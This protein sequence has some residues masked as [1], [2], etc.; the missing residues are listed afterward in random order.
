MDIGTQ[1]NQYRIVEH[2][3]RGGMADVWS[4]RDTRLNRMVAIKT[5]A[6]G[7][8]PEVDPISLFKQ[9]AQTIAQMEH[10]HILPIHDFGE[11]EGQLYIVMRY[12]AGGS[13]EDLLERGSM[14]IPEVIR[15]GTA[16]AQALDHAHS[17]DVVHLDLKPPNI[18]LDSND[19]PY[20]ADFGL[21]AVM[22]PEG[23]AQNPGS[24]TLLYMAPEQLMADELDHRADIYSFC[25]MLFHLLTG[26]LPFDSLVPLSLKQIQENQDIPPLASA[27]GE[28]PAELRLHPQAGHRPRPGRPPRQHPRPHARSRGCAQTGWGGDTARPVC[29]S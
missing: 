25:V 26:Q 22:N 9:E 23:R 8:S 13:L 29:C 28:Y 24:G 17:N 12:V 4:A 21:A 3:G 14:P 15:I 11:F 16:I 10:P 6:H 19:A 18:L 5:I 27:G 1:I 2:I 7:L 20:L